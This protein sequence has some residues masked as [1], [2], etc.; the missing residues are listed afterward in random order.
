MALLR[1][2]QEPP[3][4]TGDGADLPTYS[5]A[6]STFRSRGL[7]VRLADA[8]HPGQ[9]MLARVQT[10][11]AKTFAS[12]GIVSMSATLRGICDLSTPS[13]PPMRHTFL[14]RK[15]QVERSVIDDKRDAEIRIWIPHRLPCAC[16]EPPA[17]FPTIKGANK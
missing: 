15:A 2:S 1:P 3:S 11:H 5:D 10:D 4:A 16:G 9:E 7:I 8:Y 12:A 13:F 6:L 17:S 14:E